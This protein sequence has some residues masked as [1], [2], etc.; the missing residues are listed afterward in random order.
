ML[1]V[2]TLGVAFAAE[3]PQR[4]LM[5]TSGGMLG[6]CT[7]TANRLTVKALKGD[8]GAVGDHLAEGRLITEALCEAFEQTGV[9]LLK[10]TTWQWSRVSRPV[11]AV[12]IGKARALTSGWPPR[13][14]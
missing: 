14:R 7:I 10:R 1:L 2:A 9:I 4:D 11:A 12:G 6:A 13:R 5:S 3:L 8:L